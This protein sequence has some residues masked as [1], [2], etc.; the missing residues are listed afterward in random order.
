M[1]PRAK[2]RRFSASYK[3]R[4]LELADSCETREDV[5]VSVAQGG[6]VLF[7]SSGTVAPSALKRHTVGAMQAGRELTAKDEKIQRLKI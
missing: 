2:R 4:I 1:I 3:L 5:G 7:L 6:L